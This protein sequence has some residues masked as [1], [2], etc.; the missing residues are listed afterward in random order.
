MSSSGGGE[1]SKYEGGDGNDDF[2]LSEGQKKSRVAPTM[3][4]SSAL[5]PTSMATRSMGERK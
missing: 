3:T 5:P 4:T 2:L 1:G